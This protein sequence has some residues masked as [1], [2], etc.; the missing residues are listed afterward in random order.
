M[1]LNVT[2]LYIFSLSDIQ[3]FA[4]LYTDPGSGALVWQLLVASF[5]GGLFYI[6]SFIRRIT[7]MMSGRRSREQSDQQASID[8]AGS[9]IPNRNS[10][11]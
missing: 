10:I 2:F 1:T 9:T 4:F 11:Q 3:S 7:T 6:R 8:R 5:V